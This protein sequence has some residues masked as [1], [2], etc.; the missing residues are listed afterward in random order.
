[1]VRGILCFFSHMVSLIPAESPASVQLSELAVS[2]IQKP[3]RAAKNLHEK[4]IVVTLGA[5][6]YHL[7]R[8]VHSNK[9]QLAQVGVLHF[10]NRQPLYLP[11]FE[12]AIFFVEWG[13]S[14]ALMSSPPSHSCFYDFTSNS[15][16]KSNHPLCRFTLFAYMVPDAS[17]HVTR[18]CDCV[19]PRL[20]F[21]WWIFRIPWFFD[22]YHLMNLVP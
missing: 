21:R 16:A 7:R 8:N 3:M 4:N 5:G 17:W 19:A 22:R 20:G 2:S 15:K 11:H 18:Q 12:G 9:R 1:M 10:F 6:I 14:C 13:M